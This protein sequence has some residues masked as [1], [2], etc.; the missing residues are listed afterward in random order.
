M[1]EAVLALLRL[2]LVA[3]AAIGLVLLLRIPARRLFG[4]RI[5]YGLWS[6]VVLAVA[7]MLTPAR[8]VVLARPEPAAAPDALVVVHQGF[9]PTLQLAAAPDLSAGLAALWIGGGLAALI[10]LARS[11]ARF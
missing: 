9:A 11:Q 3:A 2:N 5:A 1:S 6:L 10:W 8:T 4:P 7:A